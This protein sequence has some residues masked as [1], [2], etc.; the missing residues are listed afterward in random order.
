MNTFKSCFL[1]T[2]CVL[3]LLVC[4][5]CLGDAEYSALGDDGGAV[6]H[7]D[8]SANATKDR[9]EP[10]IDEAAVLERRLR[11]RGGPPAAEPAEEDLVD[12]IFN[13]EVVQGAGPDFDKEGI[14]ELWMRNDDSDPWKVCTG[15][16]INNYAIV[17][18]AHCLVGLPR[19][20]SLWVRAPN[21]DWT[22]SDAWFDPHPLFTGNERSTDI[23]VIQFFSTSLRDWATSSRRFRMYAGA[24]T[25]GTGL[26]IYGYGH[27]S[28]RGGGTT[29]MLRTG[30][31]FAS[32]RVQSHTDGYFEAN[33][34]TAR[35]CV[36]DSGGPA[37]LETGPRPIVWGV[38]SEFD[39]DANCVAKD[40]QMYWA[41]TTTNI[42][43]IEDTISRKC[44]VFSDSKGNYVRCW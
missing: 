33:A 26:K 15:F 41:K 43:W 4:C 11:E 14:L 12:K 20:H 17:T 10:V 5:G 32:I 30:E 22:F 42:G 13:G 37:I 1:Q 19:L 40:D 36:G 38:A 25:E 16:V 3:G 18:A 44:N 35:T 2:S 8:S 6:L 34:A 23:G 7:P 9:Q 28:N 29:G 21:L 31:D 27:S 24:T 39:T